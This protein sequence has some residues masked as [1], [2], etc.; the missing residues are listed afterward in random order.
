MYFGLQGRHPKS[1]AFG[2][3]WYT[4]PKP[5]KI[6]HWC[7]QGEKV[8]YMWIDHDG[9]SFGHQELRDGNLLFSTDWYGEGR[10]VAASVKAK[11]AE[12]M[13]ERY[14]FMFYFIHD[15]NIFYPIYKNNKFIGIRGETQDYGKFRIVFDINGD[16]T[17]TE[18]SFSGENSEGPYT[19]HKKYMENLRNNSLNGLTPDSSLHDGEARYL[20][21]IHFS[22]SSEA[23]INYKFITEK[24]KMSGNFEDVFSAKQQ[25]FRKDFIER[26]E[27]DPNVRFDI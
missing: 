4:K 8:Q 19:A 22:F 3:L 7:D 2:L 24:D 6:R 14:F 21:Y 9:E 11:P 23:M 25:Q 5:L 16:V 17:M 15:D 13:K 26:F 10:S 18:T 12:T 20:W 27:L 1:I